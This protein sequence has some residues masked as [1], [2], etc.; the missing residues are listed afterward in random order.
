MGRGKRKAQ[1]LATR[2]A[3]Q[4]ER[5]AEQVSRSGPARPGR[6]GPGSEL[7]ASGRGRAGGSAAP[8]LPPAPGDPWYRGPRDPVTGVALAD[9]SYPLAGAR[10]I[11]RTE[12]ID[13]IPSRVQRADGWPMETTPIPRSID[14]R[15]P[16]PGGRLGG[17]RWTPEFLRYLGDHTTA[18]IQEAT[19]GMRS[20]WRTSYGR[21]RVKR[22]FLTYQGVHG[23]LAYE[24]ALAAVT[25]QMGYDEVGR[26]CQRSLPWVIQQC[27]RA[28]RYG[29]T[30]NRQPVV[31]PSQDTAA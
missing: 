14:T 16:F 4:A 2:S 10:I 25:G 12:R 21:E 9:P 3:H 17:K 8:A 11:V 23:R 30:A 31:A 28:A 24:A 15:Q 5:T 7:G 19:E 6:V 29:R 26:R 18:A 22:R 20:W 13:Y 1:W 27:D